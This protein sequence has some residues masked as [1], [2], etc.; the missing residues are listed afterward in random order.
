MSI[1]VF[2]DFRTNLTPYNRM[3]E[4]DSAIKQK[5]GF[6]Y[7]NIVVPALTCT[8]A[9]G[10]FGY[11]QKPK[12]LNMKYALF[13]RNELKKFFN[14]SEANKPC[15]GLSSFRSN[16]VSQYKEIPYFIDYIDEELQSAEGSEHVKLQSLKLQAKQL[17][18]NHESRFMDIKLAFIK[19][20][21]KQKI[22]K[23]SLFSLC[24]FAIGSVAGGLYTKFTKD[25]KAGV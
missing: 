14:D 12:N 25:K 4:S 21:V 9:A 23:T 20:L 22:T 15:M 24:G 18:N 10:T 8:V 6:R 19:K 2:S 5:N 17:L 1:G 7:A 16:P 13:A 3:V 11:L